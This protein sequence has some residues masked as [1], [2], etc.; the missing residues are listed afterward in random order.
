MLHFGKYL[1]SWCL[2]LYGRRFLIFSL[3][4]AVFVQPDAARASM[5]KSNNSVELLEDRKICQYV[6]LVKTHTTQGRM[7][8]GSLGVSRG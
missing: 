2:G 6:N 5:L 1:F 4:S 3:A 7:N 8:H